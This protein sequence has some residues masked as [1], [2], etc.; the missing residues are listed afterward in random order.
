MAKRKRPSQNNNS[1]PSDRLGH[2]ELRTIKPLTYNQQQTFQAFREG[3]NLVLHGYAGTGKTFISTYLGLDEIINDPTSVYEK[4]YFV[5]SAVSCRNLGFLPGKPSEKTGPYEE[6]YQEICEDLFGRGDGY[7]ILKMKHLVEFRPTSFMRGITF[8]NCILLIDEIQN[9]TFQEL[10]T[11]IT[12]VGENCRIIFCG[13]Y[14]QTDLGQNPREQSGIHSFM[15][16]ID[17]MKGFVH[18]EFDKDDIVRSGLVKEYIIA[19]A[20]MNIYA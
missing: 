1:N 7:Q 14:R 6:P 13:D 19:K 10:D 5:R 2:F 4:L 15:K 3:Y 8:R 9:M 11:I 16:I 17:A 20:D 12:R 18:I